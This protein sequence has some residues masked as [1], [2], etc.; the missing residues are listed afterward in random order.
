MGGELEASET[1]LKDAERWLKTAHQQTRNTSSKMVVVDEAEFRSLP[2][3]IAAARAY[4]AL[5][6]G[7]IS[8]TKMYARQTLALV[9]EDDSIHRTQAISLLGLAE[10]ASGNLHAAE[11][12]LL[13]FQA[14]MW[15]A[16]DIANAIGVTFI[17]A[18]IKLVQGQLREAVSAYRQSLQL[19]VSRGAPFFIG[20]SDL[21]RGLSE[22]LCEQGDLEATEQ[23]LLTAQQLGKQG[24]LNG[25]P[26]RLC[27][28]QARMKESQG[29]LAGALVLLD[30]A[31]RQYI[32][33]P[34][35]DRPVPAL[36]A[37]TWIRQGRLTEALS[38]VREQNLSPDDNLSYLR[39]FE[40][41]TLARVLIARYKTDQME[42]HL[43]AAFGLLARL[44][45]A[46][47][48]GGRNG[49]V[50]EIL[51]LQ[52]LAH[53]AQGNQ[54]RALLSLERA[55]TL[56]EPEG[57]VRI[58]VDEGETMRSLLEKRS[59]NR[60]HPLSGY[61]DKLLVAFSQPAVAPKSGIIHQK[62]DM[63]EPLSERELEVLK[64]LRTGLNGPDIARDRMVSLSTIRTHTQN[65]YAKLGVN[66]RRAAVLRAEELDLF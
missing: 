54:S 56:A 28:A 33:N 25:W 36:K 47:E 27:V 41:L 65:I 61:S 37:R 49:S 9:R 21:Y 5:A 53:Q 66:N 45:Q 20:A 48:E 63:I 50:I 19:A 2:A 13:K 15:Q 60:D 34:L 10:Y 11:Q 22:L 12:E 57:Y 43:H 4:C 30:E 1:R 55:L 64:L 59:L 40:H 44:L 23:H 17:L 46:A 24:A 52:S 42:G 8:G 3:S 31:E 26:H 14:I 38:W 62:S 16:N 51:I 18:N 7:D 32:R 39:E 29:D 35:P 58:I 6:L